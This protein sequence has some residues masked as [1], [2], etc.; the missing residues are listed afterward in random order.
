[1]GSDVLDIQTLLGMGPMA[2][3]ANPYPLYKRLRDESPVVETIQ[4]VDTAVAGNHRSVMITRYADVKAVLSDNDTFGSGIVNR[5]MGLV[6]GPTIVGMNG[7]EHFKHRTL[8]TPSMTPRALKGD[9]FPTL[10]REIAD[11]Y[12]DQ[13]IDE[14]AVDLHARFFFHYPLTVFVSVLGL[15]PEDVDWVHRT[16]CDL[17]LVTHEPEKGVQAAE[18][19]LQYF[20]PVIEARRR[21]GGQ[22][23]ISRLIAAQID[24]ER[25][26]DH[27]IVSFLR[28]LVLAGA[29]TTNHLLGSCF[30]QLLHNHELMRQVRANRALVPALIAE[31]MRWE[32]PIS[33][34]MRET[35]TDTHIAG[36][37]VEKGVAVLCH[38]GSANR[39]ERR[40]RAPDTFD[41]QRQ[42]KEHIAFGFGRHYCAGS[43]LARLEAE[44]GIN[45]IL[46]RLRDIEPQADEP[47]DVIGFSFRGPDRVPVTFCRA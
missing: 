25:L 21:D 15:P 9:D 17:C 4:T 43:H 14:G 38:I 31:T 5:T 45:A 12:I 40:F 41:L 36:Q 28:L 6:M 13:F 32:S 11:D 22:D 47:F 24:G 34:V 37:P 16:A 18:Q 3:V 10:I 29:E 44:I 7:R 26:S 35:H 20:T 1:M 46:D 39:D 23:M 8:I 2:P 27:E 33:T 42:D 30:Y 19:L